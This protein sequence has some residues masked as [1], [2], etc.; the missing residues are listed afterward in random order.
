MEKIEPCERASRSANHHVEVRGFGDVGNNAE[1][2]ASRSRDLCG[3]APSAAPRAP[4]PPPAARTRASRAG[5]LQARSTGSDASWRGSLPRGWNA[6]SSESTSA[7]QEASMMFSETP[8]VPQESLAVGGVEQD[9]G[10]RAGAVVR[11][12]DAHLVVGE[13]DVREVRV[14]VGDRQAERP[15]ERVHRAVPLGGAHVAPPVD[16][17]LDRRLGLDVAVGALLGDDP[18]ALEP[19]Q[20]RV[21]AGLAAQQ[22][23]ERS[24]GRLVLIAAVLALLDAL[25]RALG[26]VGVEVDA[27]PPRP[28]RG[29]SP[30]PRAR[31]SGRRGR[32]RRAPGRGARRCGRR[33]GCPRRACRPCG[34]RRCGRRRPGRG[35][36]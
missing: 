6:Y 36:G 30:C 25:E 14:E 16:P 12:E 24:V 31:R 9:A 4:A 28:R 17:D 1:G 13:L 5:S 20:R 34:R 33:P 11:V 7:S 35:P 29:P 2:F 19:E 10:D 15:V 21:L 18:E 26:G 22:Q 32:C 8:I 27:R 3:Y 23:L